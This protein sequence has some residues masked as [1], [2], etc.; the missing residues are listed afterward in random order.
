MISRGAPTPVADADGVY[1]FFESGDIF[2]LDHTGKIIWERRI[3]K[4]FGE[5]IGGHGVGTSL[6]RTPDHLILS[7]DHDG[8]S[9]IICLR[10]TTGET[11]W[12]TERTSRV[13]WSTPVYTNQSGTEQ[14]IVSSNGSVDSYDPTP[15]KQR[16][17][18]SGIK[19]NTVASPSVAADLVVIGS[20]NPG[21][22]S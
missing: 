19:G 15:G 14:I 9:Y 2:G 10:K 20:S 3:A 1:A 6:V 21:E 11:V 16:W 22:R 7:I 5:F 12:K 17:T 4:E 8:P 18:V 13:S